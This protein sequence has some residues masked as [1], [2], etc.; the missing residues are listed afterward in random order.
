MEDLLKNREVC[1]LIQFYESTKKAE[2]FKDY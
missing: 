1:I 2:G